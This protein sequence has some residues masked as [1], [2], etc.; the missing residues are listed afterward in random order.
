MERALEGMAGRR[1]FG[2]PT[3]VVFECLLVGVGF[4]QNTK[5]ALTCRHKEGSLLPERELP[6]LLIP[7]R[8]VKS[9]APQLKPR[10]LRPK[11]R[12]VLLSA[13]SSAWHVTKNTSRDHREVGPFGVVPFAE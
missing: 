13:D 11:P 1:E 4:R 9:S 7:P 10:G 2:F 3:L 6:V 5:H 12:A 8:K